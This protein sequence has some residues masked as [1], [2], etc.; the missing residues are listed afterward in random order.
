MKKTLFIGLILGMLT[1]TGFIGKGL[2]K[3]SEENKATIKKDASTAYG[4]DC[5]AAFDRKCNFGQTSIFPS[6]AIFTPV[7][8][9]NFCRQTTISCTVTECLG[10]LNVLYGFLPG[11]PKVDSCLPAKR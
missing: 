7:D 3:T 8:V 9:D 10:R 2:V 6:P 1:I 11:S 5:K 4:P